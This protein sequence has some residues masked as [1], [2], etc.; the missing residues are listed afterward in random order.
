MLL[1]HFQKAH[2]SDEHLYRS[3]LEANDDIKYA[4]KQVSTIILSEE[5][6]EKILGVSFSHS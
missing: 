2:G 5:G 3:S 6:I 4:E 1:P